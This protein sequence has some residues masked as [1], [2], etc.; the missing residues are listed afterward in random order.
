MNANKLRGIIV[1]KGMTQQ[2][3]AQYL[4]MTPKTFYSKMKK[5]VFGTDEVQRMVDLLHISDPVDIFLR[6]Q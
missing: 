5:G 3:V 6:N 4:G 2:Q 1:E